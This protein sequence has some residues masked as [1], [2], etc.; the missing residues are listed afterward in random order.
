MG[1]FCWKVAELM[2]RDD[3]RCTTSFPSAA[4]RPLAWAFAATLLAGTAP[5][6]PVAPVCP[7]PIFDEARSKAQPWRYQVNQICPPVPKYE[8]TDEGQAIMIKRYPYNPNLRECD[9]LRY[10]YAENKHGVEHWT[11]GCKLKREPDEILSQ[12]QQA[13]LTAWGQPDYLRGPYR[14]TRNETVV[15]W[16]YHPL[17][18]LFQWIDGVLVYQGPLTDR[19]RT[20]ITYGA[21]GEVMVSQVEPNIRRETWI[22]R[23]R[24]LFL[25]GGR[26]Q[27]YSFANGELIYS[28][29]TP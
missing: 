1:P 12:Q 6:E 5:A 29:E 14:T 18:R 11:R 24:T 27:I 25:T 28:Q 17:N 9:L 10:K 2:H 21:P 19:E 23:P 15:E 26:E 22:Y 3:A 7:H 4:L 8:Y 20:I 13:V 16:A